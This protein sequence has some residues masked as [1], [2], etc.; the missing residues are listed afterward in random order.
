MKPPRGL[1]PGRWEEKQLQDSEFLLPVHNPFLYLRM[2]PAWY[3]RSGWQGEAEFLELGP[4]GISRG[5]DFMLLVCSWGKIIGAPRPMTKSLRTCCNS[6]TSLG[7]LLNA[8]AL[9]H[10][11][12]IQLKS[13]RFPNNNKNDNSG[14]TQHLLTTPQKLLYELYVSKQ[15]I[16]TKT[17]WNLLFCL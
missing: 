15:F 11:D 4:V 5:D 13:K 10:G 9:P 6:Q 17:L 8:A 2:S 1:V 14:N 12:D 16:L 7:N 3:W